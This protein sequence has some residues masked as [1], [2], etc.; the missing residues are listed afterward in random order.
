MTDNI[1]NRCVAKL[2]N[3]SLFRWSIVILGLLFLVF[4]I[5]SYFFDEPLRSKMETKINQDL[6]GYTVRIPKLH[7][8]LLGFSMTLK[9]MA[10]VQQAHPNLPLIY[11]PALKA[12]INWREI[13]SGNLVAEFRLDS[14]KININLLQ[15]NSEVANNVPLNER[16]WQQAVED[17][18]PLKIN[19]L[20]IDNASITYIDQDPKKPLVLSHFNLQAH[21]IRN[22]RLPDKTYPSAFHVDTAIFDTGHGSIDGNAN[23]LAQPFPGINGRIKLEKV[24]LDRFNTFSSRSNIVLHGGTLSAAGYAEYAPKAKTVLLETMQI[25]GM[26]VDYIHSKRTAKAEKKRDAM[27]S[28]TARKLRNSPGVMLRVDQAALTGCTIAMTDE[29]AKKPYRV[30]LADTNLHISNISNQSAQGTARMTL[31]AKFMGSGATT[32][33]AEFRPGKEKTDFD[34]YVKIENARL[35]SLND[36]LMSYGNFDVSDGFFSLITEIHL[37]NDFLSGYIKPFFKDMRVYDWRKDKQRALGHQL[38]ELMVDG[39]AKILENRSHQE[40]ATKIDISGPVNRPKTSTLQ[41]IAG[42]LR[43]AFIK[44][45]VPNFEKSA[46]GS[47]KGK[48]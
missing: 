34:L 8:Q 40:V 44:A 35:T 48:I 30:F 24:P 3:S 45:I 33:S 14:P 2:I 41:M 21:N 46:S 47:R 17:I 18:Y 19:T 12:S 11:F 9:D 13:L 16:G 31:R 26:S 42:L 25:Q 7:F 28:K 1:H 22:I 32:A 23:F 20:R 4:Y 43:N 5:I 39:A 36:A 38:Y 29:A 27:V 10:V 15:L 6:K 37:K